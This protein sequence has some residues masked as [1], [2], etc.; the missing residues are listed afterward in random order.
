MGSGVTI[1]DTDRGVKAMRRRVFGKSKP[2]L[3]VGILSGD[4][5]EQD[6][7]LTVLEVAT[8]NH[9]G[10]QWVDQ[11]GREHEIPARP[12]LTGWFD[13]NESD[14]RRRLGALMQS[15]IRGERT[16][17][18]ILEILGAYC[19]GQI[20]L[21]IAAGVPPPNAPSTIEQKGSSTP[22]IRYG[23]LRGAVS[24]EVRDK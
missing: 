19:V 2:V 14:L 11:H 21:E 3:A 22:L 4:E 8:I 7:D 20:Q 9:F 13:A 17:D 5:P 6:S 15:C 1:R 24:W 12:F 18:E 10:A 23:Q 16:K